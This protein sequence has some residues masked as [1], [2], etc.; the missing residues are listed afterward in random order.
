MCNSFVGRRVE[1]ALTP[2]IVAAPPLGNWRSLSLRAGFIQKVGRVGTLGG[3]YEGAEHEVETGLRPRDIFGCRVSP[4]RPR[5]LPGLCLV[6]QG[7]SS[8]SCST[9]I[10]RMFSFTSRGG[11]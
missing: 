9:G 1:K 8:P 2:G 5:R 3:R 11:G 10:L 7:G 6:G 4:L